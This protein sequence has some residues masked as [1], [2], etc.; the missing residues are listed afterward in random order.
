MHLASHPRSRKRGSGYATVSRPVS[1]RWHRKSLGS[2]QLCDPM[3]DR[4]SGPA[5]GA[6]RSEPEIIPPD[7]PG[8]PARRSTSKM[9]LFVDPGGT[10]RIYVARLGPVGILLL[11]L[12]ICIV[13]ALIFLVLLG[14][15]PAR[16]P[17]GWNRVVPPRHSRYAR[18]KVGP[19]R[20][21]TERL[22]A[23][24]PSWSHLLT[25]GGGF[26]LRMW[27]VTHYT[28]RKCLIFLGCDGVTSFLQYERHAA[29][30]CVR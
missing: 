1:L 28:L 23:T 5:G 13:L 24:L 9:R 17:T 8:Q 26:D 7:R 10:H 15:L 11:A 16:S 25:R 27:D 3:A 12:A 22:V 18:P 6:P 19:R 4:R 21:G 14:A 29:S 2:K 30:N 20:A